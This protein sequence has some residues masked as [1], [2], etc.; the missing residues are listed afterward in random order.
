LSSCIVL[1]NPAMT[2]VTIPDG[3]L[4]LS[5]QPGLG[6]NFVHP[7]VTY[8]YGSSLSNYNFSWFF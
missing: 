7:T 3:P 6:S 1:K 4:I 2:P 8:Y 5:N